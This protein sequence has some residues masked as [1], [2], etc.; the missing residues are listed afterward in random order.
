[1]AGSEIAY[2]I[3]VRNTGDVSITD[4]S[5]NDPVI[6]LNQNIP[7]LLPG[8]EQNFNSAY[9]I[10]QD[11]IEDGSIENIVSVEG[12]TPGGVTVF[13]GD[14]ITVSA[15]QDAQLEVTLEAVPLNFT[16]IND[17]ITYNINITN[18]GNLIV[19]DITVTDNLTGFEHE[20]ENLLPGENQVL[21]TQ[22][23]IS[24]PN[25][26][27]G[28]VSNTVTVSGS[29]VGDINVSESAGAQVIIAQ[30][31][32]INLT[33]SVTPGT[34][35][36]T[37]DVLNYT[38]T[39]ENTG[40]VALSNLSVI[41]EMLDF[42]EDIANLEPGESESLSIPYAISQADINAG[43]ITNTATVSGIAPDNTPVQD[44]D[45][46]TASGIQDAAV[47]VTISATPEDYDSVG[48]EITF[49]IAVQNSGNVPL[50]AIGVEDTRTGL[51]QTIATL[52]PG[53]TNTISRS[54]TIN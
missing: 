49:S 14:E 32:A 26:I 29:G 10:E 18:T 17:L 40:N 9:S 48:D 25:L 7:L 37:D 44:S 22:F 12:T 5:D 23:T 46:A 31:P 6:G 42:E 33:K 36:D 4:I 11:D 39:V 52:A 24:L 21:T 2:T 15:I 28:I 8:Q 34:Y 41:D 50:S 13:G 1:A 30:L 47:S 38:I 54:Y 3:V 27:A 35:D 51:D 20:I 53:A 43:E 19:S 16:S 45:D